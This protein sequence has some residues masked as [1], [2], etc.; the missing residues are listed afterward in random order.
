MSVE[1]FVYVSLYSGLIAYL[2]LTI[3]FLVGLVRGISGRAGLIASAATT[4]WIVSFLALGDHPTVHVLESTVYLTWILLLARILG[5]TASRARKPEYR[6]Q[7][8]LAVTA[9]IVYVAT[10]APIAWFGLTYETASRAVISGEASLISGLPISS[11]LAL[12][13]I[14]IVMVE[15]VARNA[16]RDYLWNIKFIIIGLATVF[17]YGFVLYAEAMLFQAVSMTLLAPQAMIY[18]AAAPLIGIGTLRNRD[19]QLSLN[20]S[21]RFVFRTG[22]IILAGSYLLIMSAAGYYVQIFGGQWADVFLVVLIAAGAIGLALLVLSTTVRRQVRSA[23]IANLYPYRYDYREEWLR[24]NRELTMLSADD[25][26]GVR[27]I[28][29]LAQVIDASAGGYWRLTESGLLVPCA[30]FRSKWNRALSPTTTAS[31]VGYYQAHDWIIDLDEYRA[32][33]ESHPELDLDCTKLDF[34]NVSLIVPLFVEDRLFGIIML[35]KP[36]PTVALNWEEFDILKMI[37]QQAAGF[38]ALKQLDEVLSESEQLRMMHQLSAFVVHDLKTIAAQMGLLL[39]NADKHR[40][41]PGFVD[42]MITTVRNCSTKVDRLLEQLREPQSR[43]DNGSVDVAGLAREAVEEHRRRGTNIAIDEGCS[44]VRVAAD[45]Q[46]LSSVI[47]HVIQNAHEATG[48]DGAVTV[49][50]SCDDEWAMVQISDNGSGMTEHFIANEL[51]T[52]FVSTK[53]VAGMG[54]GAYQ[55]REYIRSIGGDVEVKSAPG[56]GTCFTLRIPLALALQA[57]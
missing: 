57:S 19:N 51:F 9:T 36:D 32:F 55:T 20:V 47:G 15:Q 45:P 37:A 3:F 28:R 13:L 23:L 22:S 54:I 50:V 4:L 1:A 14:G 6:T 44:D 40:D 31:L 25:S 21:R 35:D 46:K 43:T 38:L 56:A 30:Q 42:D 5:V 8:I 34:H 29:A 41:K 33:P 7:T 11:K 39:R 26:L 27:A 53:G 52:P 48:T 49:R 10:M 17:I 18:A 12:T 16:R 24:L 2:G